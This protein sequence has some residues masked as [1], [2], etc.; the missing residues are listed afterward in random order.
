MLITF[1]EYING[2]HE[3]RRAFGAESNNSSIVGPCGF[4]PAAV[5]SSYQYAVMIACCR[6]SNSSDWPTQIDQSRKLFFAAAAERMNQLLRTNF[7]YG[8]RCFAGRIV[9][10]P[11]EMLPMVNTKMA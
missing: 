8:S 10:H 7:G 3:A 2:A 6:P 4:W 9:L 11:P 1:I 5:K